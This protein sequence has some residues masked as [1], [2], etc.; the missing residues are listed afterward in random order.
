MLK[1]KAEFDDF[2]NRKLLGKFAEMEVERQQQL[3]VF[4]N[5]MF[6]TAFFIPLLMLGCWMAFWGDM[7]KESENCLKFTTYGLFLYVAFTYFYCSSPIINFIVAIKKDVMEE[8]AG[9]WGNF[10]YANGLK[11]LFGIFQKF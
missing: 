6:L 7:V 4:I 8:F 5:R 11:I 1:T 2:Y 10:T 3:N 9:F